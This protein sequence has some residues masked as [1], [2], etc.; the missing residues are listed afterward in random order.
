MSSKGSSSPWWKT[1]QQNSK[2]VLDKLSQ[3]HH[4]QRVVILTQERNASTVPGP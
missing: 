4:K 3:E 2:H 1:I